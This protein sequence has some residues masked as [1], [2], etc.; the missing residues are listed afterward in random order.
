MQRTLL[1]SSISVLMLSATAAFA[2]PGEGMRHLD[3]NGDGVIS[4]EEAARA[5]RLA[6][7]FDAIDTNKDGK[8][9]PDEMRAFHQQ[10]QMERWSKIDTDRDG[11][12]SRD[13]AKANAPHMAKHFDEID[14]N[15]DGFITQD[16]LKAARRHPKG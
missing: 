7:N 3:T 15:R 1:M 2:G 6:Q 12:I 8:L 14:T 5:P 16:E 13:E 10:K 9:T 11:R 4:R